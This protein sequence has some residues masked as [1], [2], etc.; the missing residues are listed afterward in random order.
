[1]STMDS[2]VMMMCQCR[3]IN[4]HKCTTLAC[5]FTSLRFLAKY[6]L[7]KGFFLDIFTYES[8][9]SSPISGMLYSPTL[10]LFV[11]LITTDHYN[12][13]LFIY[14]FIVCLLHQNLNSI[15]MRRIL[16]I[17]FSLNAHAMC[18]AHSRYSIK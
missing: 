10:F 5:S 18:L 17:L 14:L 11:T 8:I 13:Y 15:I 1:M 2:G 3:F 12:I 7:L 16:S 9:I 6:H 4:C